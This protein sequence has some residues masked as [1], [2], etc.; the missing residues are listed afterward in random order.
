MKV[1]SI[2][3][4][5]AAVALSVLDVVQA[6]LSKIVRV[7]PSTQHY[8]DAQGR[9]RFFHG[10]NMVKKS[11]PWHHDVNNFTPSWSI[12]DRDIELMKSLNINIVRLGKELSVPPPPPLHVQLLQCC[13]Y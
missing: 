4:A 5:I 8:I 6:D 9:S 1:L 11:F 3:A 2:T 12:V 13:D 7:N 10:T